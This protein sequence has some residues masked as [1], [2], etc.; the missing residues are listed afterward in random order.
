MKTILQIVIGIAIAV[1][2]YLLYDS[3][4]HPI[5][6]NQAVQHRKDL[7][8]ERLIDIRSLQSSYKDEHG[9]FTE[10]FD[11]LIHYFKEGNVSVVRQIGSMDDTAA[12]ARGEVRRDT[13]R[14]PARDTL[15]KVLK[16]FKINEKFNIDSLRYVPIVGDEFEM[17]AVMYKS[18]SNI[19]IPLFEAGVNND[20]YLRGL[21]RQLIVNLN[22]DQKKMNKWPGVKVGSIDQPNNNAG[23]W[24]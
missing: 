18:I 17:K 2:A 9:K 8:V 5:R 21:D 15:S 1:L 6:F 4:M 11:S 14:I 10:S 19:M 16:V 12:V 24:E 3:L 13:I 23:N 22:D 20:V 7:V